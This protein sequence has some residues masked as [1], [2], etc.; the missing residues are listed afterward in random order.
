MTKSKNAKQR[1]VCALLVLVLAISSL[2][3]T[4]FAWFTDSVT[5]TGNK[6]QSGSLKID[7]LHKVEDAWVSVSDDSEH[8]IFNYEKWEP[9]YTRVETLK[10]ENLGTLALKY[11]LSLEVEDGSAILGANGEN[12]AD[13]IDVYTFFGQT[14][15]TDLDTIK[16]AWTP[17]GT[18]T[19]VMKNPA[20]FIGGELLPKGTTPSGTEAATTAVGEQVMMVA[21]T[22]RESAGNEYQN[23]SVGN[24][25]VNLIATQFSYEGDSLGNDY[26]NNSQWPNNIIVGANSATATVTPT[27]EGKV[28]ANGVSLESA[29][30]K[31]SASVPEGVQLESGAT[32]LTLT[33]GSVNKSE[34]NITLDETEATVSIDVHIAG[35]AASNTVPIKV[36]IKELLP[37]GL[38]I[39]NYRLYHVENGATNL[40]TY[41]TAGASAD[42]NTFDYDPATG[43]VYLYLKSFSEVALVAEPPK[44]EG[45]FDYTWYNNAVAPTAEG[46]PDYVIANADQLAAFGAIV[47]GMDGQTQNSFE[48][49]YIKLVADV[50]LGDKESEN[51]PDLIFYPIGY[52]NSTKSYEKSS[53]GSVTSGFKNFEGTFDGNGNTIS[54]FYQNTWEMFGDYNDGYSGTPNHYRDGMGLFGR[55]YGGTVKNLTVENFSSDGEITTTGVIAAYADSANGKPAIFEN[56]SIIG[57]NPRVYNI[58]N[59][60]IVGCAGWYSRNESLGNENYTN[61]VTFRNITVDQSNKISALWGT[62]DVSCGGI[63][64]QYYPDSNCGVKLENCH[65]SAIIDVNNDVCANYQYYW[66]R[67]S[68]MFIGTIRANTKDE[69]GYTV[70]DPTG[71]T[72]TGCTYSYGSWNEYWY[73]ELVKNSSAS[74]THDYQFGRLTNIDDLSEIKSGETWLKEGNFALVSDDRKSVECYHIFK[75]SNGNLYRHFHDVA[76]ESN[77]NIYEDFDLNGDGELN[78]LK[79]D[80]QRY[81]LPFGQVFNGLGYGVKPTYTF[82]GFTLVE[83]GTVISGE[84]FSIKDNADLTYRRGDKIYLKDL[85]DLTVDLSKLSQSSLYV[86]ASPV[87]DES[88][89]NIT[90]HRDVENWE[91]NYFV[92]SEDSTGAIKLVIT[93]YF[94]C[95]PTV[96]YL[97]PEQA[98]E[99]FTP[100]SIG[101]QNAYTQITLGELFGVEEGATIGNVTATVT[102]P[103]GTEI[104]VTG[105]SSDWATKTIDLTKDGNWK[106][107]IKDDDAYCSVT[108]VTFTVN[109]VNKFTN[110]FDKDFLYRVGNKNTV[111]LGTIF[112]EIETNISLSSVSVTI[113][114]IAG[115][116]AGTFTSNVT[117]TSG[118][119]QFTGT[120]V[121]TVTISADGAN[122]VSLN[123]E[124]VDATNLTSATG[125][126]S[127]GSFVLLCDVNTTSYVYYYDA[128]LYGNGFTYSLKGAPTTYSSSHGHG[129]L[130]TK[131]ATLDN[132][133]IVGDVYDEYGAYTN[134]NDYNAA[135]DVS[136]D[137]VIQNCYISGCSAPVSTRANATIINTTLY[138]GAVANLLI[139]GGTITLENV[140][141]ANYNDGRNAP[142]GMGIVVHSDAT[143]SAKLI[144]NGTL[145]Q[146]NFLNEEDTPTDTYAKNLH[147]A[148]FGTSLSTYHF[149][150]SPNRRVNTGVVSLT[151]TFNGEDITDNANTGYSGTSVTLSA[152]NGYVYTQP[153]TSGS[154]NNGYD[155]ESDSHVSTTQG[156]VPPS[157]SFDHTVNYVAKTDASNDYCYVENGIVYISMDDGDSFNYNTSILTLGK[158]LTDY[159]VSMNGTDYTGKPITFN[160]TGNYEIVYTY[161][162]SNNYKLD[163][164]GNIVTYSVTYTQTVNIVVA[165][166]KAT[167]KHAEFTFGSSNTLSTTVTIGNSTYVMPDVSATSSIGSITVSGKT[168]Y[169]PIVDAYTSDGAT[170]HTSLN[171]WYMCYPVFK[172]VISITDYESGGT[173]NAVT[174]GSS[175]TTKPVGLSLTAYSSYLSSV[176]SGAVSF[177]SGGA[178]V[179]FKYQAQASASSEPKNLDNV[180]IYAS[181]TLTDNARNELYLLVQYK[182]Q[183]N[184][185]AIYYYYVGYHMPQTTV[186]SISPC[187]TPDT[188]VTLSD[189]TQKRIDEVTY[190]DQILVWNFYTGEYDVV[191][192]AI[193]FDHGYDY[194]TVITLKFSDGTSVKAVNL[195]QFFDA[196]LNE[197]VSID[198]NSVADYVGHKFAKSNGNGFDAVTL[199]D[200]TV[201]VEYVEAWGIISSEHYNIFVEG[202]LSTD[203]MLE[204]Y[205][206]FNCFEIGENMTFDEAKMQSDI[207]KYGLYTYEDFADYLTYEQFVAFNVQYFKIAV[208]KGNYTYEGILDL[209]DTYLNQ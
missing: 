127:G 23:L 206:L 20:S 199:V 55:V 104:T 35:V 84:K 22:M 60:G 146:Y 147:S 121:V 2:I 8:K 61:A 120:G 26:D 73:C 58:G 166:V 94:Y 36:Y 83:D 95:T 189:G 43:D 38:N 122:S 129:V 118:T 64:G 99:K 41:L 15:V 3:G 39:G 130:I 177:T 178:D 48:G 10:A 59:G 74:Y 169:Y 90:Y 79:E 19:E 108:T 196:D 164:N 171:Q 24:I 52:Y 47:G 133:V 102:D 54:N 140:T 11:K 89:V 163:K 21:L 76:D 97:N 145:T 128:A 103:N 143:E 51:N 86:A 37:T 193:I 205:D 139:K 207:E 29:D 170:E 194:N 201:S 14:A 149:G 113:D 195:H 157:Y 34:A 183:D 106:V 112:E 115:N 72:A 161:T 63:L 62:Y 71:I 184:A 40:M 5:S 142:I 117:W 179:A 32:A 27:T 68:G 155:K 136:G 6:I 28:D 17:K 33:V 49:K 12:L 182:Y 173:G 188:L 107:V 65:V 156:A 116:A 16:A 13:V 209:I 123:L 1:L 119:I 135:I 131:N 141:T 66:Y 30:Q 53:G 181:P 105:T 200:Y 114:T 77:P 80:R 81:Y 154:V 132:L 75:D 126:T 88:S 57:C 45:N 144:L 175:T 125:T 162:D 44:W 91:N 70:A 185:G 100:N 67:Y 167:T 208:G 203:F 18:L 151:A 180:L 4:T 152:V 186:K 192:S 134:N 197:F 204:D 138:G 160:T 158:N 111:N 31:I 46:E 202:M 69:S 187:V 176:P 110:K 165:V 137:T 85:V 50:N 9:G 168:I 198:A 92:I 96:I 98:K 153:N 78:D 82:D 124:V 42:H 93:D 159:T 101:A 109:K 191:S 56:I 190:A 174:Y 150:T 7:L 25:Y 172:N 87:G 148:M